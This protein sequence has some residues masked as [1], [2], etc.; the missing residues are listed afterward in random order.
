MCPFQKI[1]FELNKKSLPMCDYTKKECT[2]CVMGNAKTYN[3]AV[4]QRSDNNA[5]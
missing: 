5:E 1:N 4:K 3:E 2:L